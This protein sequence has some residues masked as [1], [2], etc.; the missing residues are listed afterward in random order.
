MNRQVLL[1]AIL[2]VTLLVVVILGAGLWLLRDTPAVPVGGAATP[3]PTVTPYF[4]LAYQSGPLP[5]LQT[6]S[7]TPETSPSPGI[8]EQ[9]F[10]YGPGPSERPAEAVS[11]PHAEKQAAPAP[12]QTPCPT[13]K[14]RTASTRQTY[15]P[16]TQ[17][18]A[19]RP[20]ARYWIQTGSYKSKSKADFRNATL[21]ENGISGLIIPKTVHGDTYFRVRVGPYS[22]KAEAEKWLTWIKKLDGFEQSYISLDFSAKR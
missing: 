18:A 21:V 13:P 2:A 11:T 14:A 16:K 12:R 22:V 19:K 20:V 5:G 8:E 6:P 4:D 9:K 7:P 17:P 3:E 15:V 1:W 10:S